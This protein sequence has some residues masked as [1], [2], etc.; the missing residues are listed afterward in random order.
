M[1]ADTSNV[2]ILRVEE[3]SGFWIS[4]IIG[5]SFYNFYSYRPSVHDTAIRRFVTACKSPSAS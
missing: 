3:I 5:D 1:L 4:V 2:A